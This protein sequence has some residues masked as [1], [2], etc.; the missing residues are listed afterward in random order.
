[1]PKFLAAGC[2]G[3]RGIAIA[4]GLGSAGAIGCGSS[5]CT[6]AAEQAVAPSDPEPSE[7]LEALRRAIDRLPA[8]LRQVVLMHYLEE[9]SVKE[10]AALLSLPAKTIE[11]R[12]HQAR[13]RWP[14]ARRRASGRQNW[15]DAAM[16]V[17]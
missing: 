15:K 4:I 3:W 13:R 11:G 16:P 10:I 14:H 5:R 12:L 17:N 9:T 6:G 8:K 7:R 1:M 2:V